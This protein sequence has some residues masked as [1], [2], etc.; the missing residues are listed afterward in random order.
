MQA[1]R[2]IS[3]NARRCLPVKPEREGADGFPVGVGEFYG[4][5]YDEEGGRREHGDPDEEF[6]QKNVILIDVFFSPRAESNAHRESAA[7]STLFQGRYF[8][9]C[10]KT[11]PARNETGKDMV[12]KPGIEKLAVTNASA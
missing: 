12:G 2:G 10:E 3:Q 9:P 5:S 7:L 8:P 11:F 4:G 6:F 1:F